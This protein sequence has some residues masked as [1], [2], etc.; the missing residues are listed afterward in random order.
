MDLP[1]TLEQTITADQL[2]DNEI[3]KVVSSRTFLNARQ[4]GDML[5]AVALEHAAIADHLN[6]ALPALKNGFEAMLKDAGLDAS[7]TKAKIGKLGVEQMSKHI[8]DLASFFA[9]AGKV[10]A[11]DQTLLA[12]IQPFLDA[13]EKA[14]DFAL[15]EKQH[16][17]KKYFVK[18]GN[19]ELRRKFL[20]DGGTLP[21]EEAHR[22][23]A[24]CGHCSV[25]E[26]PANVR[27]RKHNQ[28]MMKLFTDEKNAFDND[29]EAWKKKN[30]TKKAPTIPSLGNK[31]LLP[32]VY[33]CHCHEFACNGPGGLG[34]CPMCVKNGGQ[35]Q[36][37]GSCSCNMCQCRCS[38]SIQV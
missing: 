15:Q 9:K 8:L 29:P 31:T 3:L 16:E 23:C 17:F 25:D 26:P 5:L 6:R 27:N 24:L 11:F 22:I 10:K 7:T 30:G 1:T 35:L 33:R 12:T 2:T 21:F 32:V 13:R 19:A 36:S 37:D 4:R 28:A 38:A 20:Q 14:I 18:V 34:S